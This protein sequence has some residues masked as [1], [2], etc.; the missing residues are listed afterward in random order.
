VP[1]HVGA[2]QAKMILQGADVP[3]QAVAAVAPWIGWYCRLPGAPQVQHDQLPV[4]GQATEIA[5]VSRLT[6]WPAGQTDQRETFSLDVV[7]EFSSVRGAEGGHSCDAGI[8]RRPTATE[9]H[10]RPR[11]AT[12]A[13]DVMGTPPGGMIASLGDLHDAD[14]RPRAGVR[15]HA[16]LTAPRTLRISVPACCRDRP[17]LAPSG[18]VACARDVVLR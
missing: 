7:G 5:E 13:R 6:H 15:T 12:R 4:P 11:P 16:D 2:A 8:D 3:H 9:Y 17:E 18:E 14:W 1:Q 10:R